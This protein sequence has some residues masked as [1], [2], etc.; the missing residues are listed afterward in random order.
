MAKLNRDMALH[1][2]L[3]NNKNRR[4]PI[5]ICIDVSSKAIRRESYLNTIGNCIK[6][7]MDNIL[8]QPSMK[9]SV[10]L[11]VMAYAEKAEVKREFS[12]LT[13]HEDFELPRPGNEP[14]MF[15]SLDLCLQKLQQRLN[16]YKN[17][18]LSRHHPI[19]VILS[20]GYTSESPDEYERK[21]ENWKSLETSRILS[22]LPILIGDGD[23]KLLRKMTADQKIANATKGN[24]SDL[25]RE[26]GNSVEELSNSTSE[27]YR[28]LKANMVSWS[29]IGGK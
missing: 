25:I 14:N 17:T 9:A 10:D 8:S 27:A 20:S 16:E 1:A 13:N 2:D 22:V 24:L 12:S 5:C 15:S 28:N 7:L 11:F 6:E 26:I 23:D 18:S 21:V 29:D 4:L 19:V 3:I